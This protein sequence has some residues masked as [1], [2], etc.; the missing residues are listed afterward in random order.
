[1]GHAGGKF[2]GDRHIRRR[3]NKV[4]E[5]MLSMQQIMGMDINSFGT[6]DP[7]DKPFNDIL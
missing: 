1:M 5:L 7:T 4:T 2:P 3:G 6:W